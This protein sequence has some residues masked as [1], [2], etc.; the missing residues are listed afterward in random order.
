MNTVLHLCLLILSCLT[1]T[2]T[3]G[4][5]AGD[6]AFAPVS[7]NAAPDTLLIGVETTDYAPYYHMQ[8]ERYSGMARDLLDA[9]LADAHLLADYHPLPVPRLFLQF[10]H[11]QLDFK[12]P[13]NPQWSENLKAGLTIHYS[14]PV[15]QVSEAV[16]ILNDH[17]GPVR[18]VGTI[19]GF[20][21][22]GI[23]SALSRGDI[24]L[25]EV[26]GMEQLLK[27]L[28]SGR[29]DGIYFNVRVAQEAAARRTQPL[30]LTMLKDI[31]PYRYAYHL[32]SIRHP[33]LIERFDRFMRENPEVIRAIRQS[34]DLP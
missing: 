4:P 3:A 17:Q 5:L 23:S 15:F 18:N 11:N 20:T 22:P 10:T 21:T 31:A 34:Y 30:Q 9:F 26:T 16:M 24:A 2:A 7:A 8:D 27:M 33:R 13:D 12:F 28:E 29:I 14:Q 6:Q 25:T 1:L 19:M 32:S